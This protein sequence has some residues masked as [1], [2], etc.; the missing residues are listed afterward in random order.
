MRYVI[1][2]YDDKGNVCDVVELE[3]VDL[4]MVDNYAAKYRDEHGYEYYIIVW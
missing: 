1:K 3:Y 4:K 2:F